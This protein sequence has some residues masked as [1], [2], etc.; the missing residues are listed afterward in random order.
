MIDALYLRIES[1]N[2]NLSS[3]IH[4]VYQE[5]NHRTHFL[6]RKIIMSE[7]E[8]TPHIDDLL[9][10]SLGHNVFPVHDLTMGVW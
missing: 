2:W 10:K 7:N 1:F 4:N 3:N 8:P 6:S 9:F 5:Q